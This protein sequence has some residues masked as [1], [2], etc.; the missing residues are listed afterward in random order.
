PHFA[1]PHAGLTFVALSEYINAWRDDVD[2]SLEEAEW[3]ARRAIELD[4]GEPAGYAALGNALVWQRR[5]GDALAQ[6]ERA[7]ALDANYAQGRALLGMVLMYAGRP[8]E[9]LAPFAT[10]MRLDPHYP[11]VVLHLLAQAHF[12]LG[13]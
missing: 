2:A 11:N 7:V 3:W 1:A 4:D 8:A 5:H 13:Q 6:I 10:A 12:S 9:A